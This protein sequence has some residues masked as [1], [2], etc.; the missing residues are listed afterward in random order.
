MIC[1]DWVARSR[2]TDKGSRYDTTETGCTTELRSS[3]SG[4]GHRLGKT[5]PHFLNELGG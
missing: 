3:N 4:N 1:V 5:S 2:K